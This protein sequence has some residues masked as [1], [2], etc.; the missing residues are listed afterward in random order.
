MKYMARATYSDG[1]SLLDSGTD[2]N[3]EQGLAE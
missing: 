3:M 1:G 2:L